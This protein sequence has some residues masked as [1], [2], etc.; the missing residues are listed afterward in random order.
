MTKTIDT[1]QVTK[2]DGSL[3]QFDVAQ[4]RDAINFAIEGIE[5]NPLKL[6]T[7][8]NQSIYDGIATDKIQDSLI[9]AAV[10]LVSA[11]EPNW[12]YVAGRLITWSRQHRLSKLGIDYKPKILLDYVKDKVCDKLVYSDLI[13][14]YTDE[15]LIEAFSWI[16]PSYDHDYDVFGAEILE[17]RYLLKD[18]PL[19]LAYVL[20]ALI[21]AIPEKSKE[22]RMKFAFKLYHAIAQRK[23]SLATPILA[24]MRKAKG[25][26]SSCFIITMEDDLKS[27][28][29][30][31]T[32]AAFI[33]KNGGGVG[34]NVSRIR[35]TGSQVMGNN[36]ASG[37]VI[38]WIKLLN[39][40]AIAV[41]QGKQNCPLVA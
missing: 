8:F 35:A 9:V 1:L 23:I 32:N 31:I 40:T 7:A 5:L 20:T 25:S 16:N 18:E 41:N 36:N 21:I 24:N 29:R 33:S 17:K 39:D 38:P 3:E 10:N 15:Q 11:Q 34:C 27:I 6:E 12:K 26:I 19:Q 13:M 37:G 30:E 14:K 28:Y 4:I 22:A 2:R